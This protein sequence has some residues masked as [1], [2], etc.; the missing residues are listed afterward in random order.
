MLIAMV[1]NKDLKI[2]VVTVDNTKAAYHIEGNV[3]VIH[4]IKRLK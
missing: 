4:Y 2:K 1:S 3:A